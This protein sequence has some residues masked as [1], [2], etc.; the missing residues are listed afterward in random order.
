MGN[1]MADSGL[2]SDVQKYIRSVSGLLF[3]G[4]STKKKFI[5]D[6]KNDISD[7]IE[8]ENVTDIQAIY[9]H[10]G[11]PEKVA[12]AFFESA[13][14][15]EIH[16]KTNIRNV[17]LAAVIAVVVVWAVYMT[18]AVLDAHSC[19]GGYMVPTIVTEAEDVSKAQQ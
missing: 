18:I 1:L 11:A 5:A 19:N 3:C 7:F 17:L 13:D 12:R 6:L 2:Q 8:T 10:F 14:L 9:K 4:T 16:R 15:H